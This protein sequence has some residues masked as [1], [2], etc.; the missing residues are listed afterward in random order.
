MNKLNV[1]LLDVWGGGQL[2]AF[3]GLDGPTDYDRGLVARTSFDCAGF[4]VKLPGPCRICFHAGPLGPGRL[5]LAGD[6]FDLTTPAGRTRGAFLD[7][8]HL[9]IEGPCEV[10]DCGERIEAVEVGRR[11]LIAAAGDGFDIRLVHADLDAAVAARRAWLAARRIPA[12]LP[13]PRRRALAKALSVMKGQ[14]CTPQFHVRHRWTTPDRWPHR[15]LWLWDSAFHAIGWRHVD[16]ALAREMLDAVFDG[17]ADDGQIPIRTVPEAGHAFTQPPVLALACKLVDEAAP[18]RQWLGRA[19][20]KLAAYI[21]WDLANRDTDGAGLAEWAIEGSVNCRSGES[22]MDN[23]PR[24]DSATQLDATDFNAFLAAEC[25]ILA[26]LAGLL[27]RDDDARQWRA[28]HERL[29]RLI[30]ER[31]WNEKAGTYMDCDAATGRQTGVLASAGLLPL[32]C[33]APSPPQAARLADHL[34][35]ERTFGTALRVPTI[36][37]ADTEHYAKDMWRGPVWVNLN[38]L[39]ARGLDR[40]GHHDLAAEIRRDTAAEIEAY[41]GRYGTLFEFY[42][43]RREVDPPQLLRKGKCA[44]QDSPFHQVFFDYGWTATLYVDMVFAGLPADRNADPRTPR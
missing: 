30:N 39:I 3:S 5:V 38:W 6:F 24:F 15:G 37:A 16:A 43:D 18:D 10:T 4:D 2:F 31:L 27:G 33:G 32:L 11:T 7:A 34:T 13:H 41:H 9:L 23:S 25:E 19:Y 42:D 28:A 29:C 21:R 22:G 20:P 8:C 14:V 44:P 17:Q 26:E 12:G 40:Y 35:D 36:A 1:S